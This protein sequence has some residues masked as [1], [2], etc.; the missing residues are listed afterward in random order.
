[1]SIGPKHK[2]LLVEDVVALATTF[3]THLEN[4]GAEV[5]ICHTAADARVQLERNV[6]SLILLD[7][8]LPEI[9]GF[10]VLEEIH[11]IDSLQR[12]PVVILTASDDEGD[13]VKCEG[14][15]VQ[16]FIRKPVNLEKFVS[17]VQELRRDWLQ[18]VLLPSE[19]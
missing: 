15:A 18:D 13:Q 14:L 11:S 2:I 9:D 17:V 6:Y 10:G 3:G 7:L 19:M 12:V 16:S 1:M 8:Q 5:H 4:D